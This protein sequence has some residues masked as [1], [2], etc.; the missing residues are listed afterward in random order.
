MSKGHTA[1][2]AL[3]QAVAE[4]IQRKKN[5]LKGFPTKP[6][7]F[8]DLLSIPA[9]L[10][11]TSDG[12]PFLVFNEPVFSGDRLISPP[13]PRREGIFQYIGPSFAKILRK[14]FS[15]TTKIQIF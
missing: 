12:K 3:K 13:P 6:K 2:I 7:V 14:K 10:T 15:I 5:Q 11:V 4:A 1:F 8:V 9:K